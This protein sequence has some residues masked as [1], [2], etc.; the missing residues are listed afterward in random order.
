MQ[1]LKTALDS[2]DRGGYTHSI[3]TFVFF[4]LRRKPSVDSFFS[5]WAQFVR[6][7]NASNIFLVVF[8]SFPNK[9]KGETAPKKEQRVFVLFAL[10]AYHCHLPKKNPINFRLNLI[11]EQKEI[12][13]ISLSC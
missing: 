10:K 1:R 8:H 7:L 6:V 12:A 3:I 9:S 11:L 13:Q 5:L 4:I 2:F